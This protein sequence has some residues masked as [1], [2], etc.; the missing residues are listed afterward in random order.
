MDGREVLA[1]FLIEVDRIEES[2]DLLEENA[3]SALG[4]INFVWTL[5]DLA[6]AASR[7]NAHETATALS[8][9]ARLECRRSGHSPPSLSERLNSV[10]SEAQT[11][12][13]VEEL[14]QAVARGELLNPTDLTEV[15]SELRSQLTKGH[16]P[17]R[18]FAG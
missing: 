18:P 5:A 13:S 4:T 8:S 16:H 7:I 17:T 11:K 12:L 2:L 9:L 10:E 15:I 1:G 6:F 3:T 14:R